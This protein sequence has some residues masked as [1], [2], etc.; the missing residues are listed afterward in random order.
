M[1]YFGEKRRTFGEMFECL[2]RKTDFSFSVTHFSFLLMI[3]CE[4]VR[5]LCHY[6]VHNHFRMSPK[7]CREGGPMGGGDGKR[8]GDINILLGVVFMDDNQK[9]D[10]KNLC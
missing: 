9:R 3:P 4:C 1:R 5:A 10:G 7:C 6:A 8:H 2:K